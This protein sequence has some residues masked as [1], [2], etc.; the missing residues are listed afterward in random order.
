MNKRNYTIR[1]DSLF[2]TKTNNKYKLSNIWYKDAKNIQ[3]NWIKIPY[4][5]YN[6]TA[7]NNV[8]VTSAGTVTITPGQYDID[9]ITSAIQ[10][11]LVAFDATFTVTYSLIT[12][13]I[14]IA[15]STNFNLTLASSTIN[16][17]I[18]FNNTNKTGAST[19]T[20]D[21]V[22]DVASCPFVYFHSKNLNYANSS[23]AHDFREDV[24]M[25][26]PC[27]VTT[28]NEIFY[29]PELPIRFLLD[30]NKDLS[31]D[32]WWFSTLNTSI[33]DLNNVEWTVNLDIIL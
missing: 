14:T 16:R 12:K 1:G 23:T 32:T 4:S 7:S 11:Q 31:F 28:S 26:V 21:N 19:Y 6:I 13:K 24:I 33:I 10:T 8:L 3:I 30:Q 25:S 9:D 27:N 5:F 17:N 15:R 2:V 20:S 29:M 22:Y 18:G